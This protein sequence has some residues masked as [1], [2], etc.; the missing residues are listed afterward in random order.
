MPQLFQIMPCRVQG[1]K[2]A[3]E[4]FNISDTYLVSYNDI[5]ING[6]NIFSPSGYTDHVGS[7]LYIPFLSNLFST[8]IENTAVLFFSL[9]GLFCI[10]LSLIGLFYFYN[11]KFAKIYGTLIITIIGLICIF[12]G[13]TYCFYGLTSI[14]LTTW[15]SKIKEL[16][17][18]DYK[19]LIL[20]FLLTGLIISFSNSV[21][22]NSGD[23]VLLS[24]LIITILLTIKD[25]KIY[26][27]ISILLIFMPIIF[28]NLQIGSLKNTA[29]NYLMKNDDAVERFDLNFVRATWHNAYYSLG[30]LSTGNED[31]PE[32]SDS[33][34]V[35]KAQ[36]INPNVKVFSAEY[37]QILKN[38]YLK[39]VKKYPLLFIQIIASK[40]GV[41][42]L[43]FLIF[44]N[45]GIYFLAKYRIKSETFLFFMPGIILNS[46]FGIATEPNYTYLLG[47]FAYSGLFATKL[48]EDNYTR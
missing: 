23:D 2:A 14:A 20:L 46:A 36:K 3:L 5:C 21:R 28:V 33:F 26:R 24:I 29:R 27:I 6:N 9:Y 12:I 48:I 8:T 1:Y 19:K 39:F 40:T 4:G 42:F 45:I 43:Y 34:S 15:W 38:E 22:G 7:Y 18:I 11:S 10:L 30:Y 41:I 13:D 44:F 37:E 47:L 31:V 16:E 32:P 25:K 35:K 17:K